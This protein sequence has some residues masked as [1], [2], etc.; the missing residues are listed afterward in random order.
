M[1]EAVTALSTFTSRTDAGLDFGT[2]MA[3]VV[4]S[5]DPSIGTRHDVFKA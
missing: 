2:S 1:A 4:R 3:L 5:A